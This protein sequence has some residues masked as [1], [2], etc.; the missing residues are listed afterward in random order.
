MRSLY[1]I[2]LK[3]LFTLLPI[4]LTIALLAWIISQVEEIFA[5]PLKRQL[6]ELFNFPGTGLIF[7][8][9]LV[10]LAGVLVNSYLT[11]HFVDWIETRLE[12]LPIVRAIYSPIRDVTRLFADT[13]GRKAGQKVVM[14]QLDNGLELIGL[15]TRDSFQDLP[16]GTVGE[17]H[18]TVFLPFSYGMG[19]FTAIVSRERIRETDLSAE[20]AMQLAITGWIK[21]SSHS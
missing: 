5:N 1:R 19:G 17:G 2:F 8:L 4:L 21:N 10:L 16:P 7:A 14:V 11:R 13:E 12:R 20:R 9:I 3:G 18:V 15:V 6:P